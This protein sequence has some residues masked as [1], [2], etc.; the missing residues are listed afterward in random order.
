LKALVEKI[1]RIIDQD[2]PRLNK[3]MIENNVPYI[4]PIERIK[5]DG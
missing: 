5:L 1:N 3:L 2:V 4:A